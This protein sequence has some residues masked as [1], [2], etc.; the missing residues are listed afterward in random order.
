MVEK[1]DPPE[2]VKRYHVK[3]YSRVSTRTWGNADVDL[4]EIFV[5]KLLEEI[6]I[7]PIV[8]FIPNIHNTK[9]GLCIATEEGN[10]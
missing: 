7:G 3:I 6:N 1:T 8:H 4:R 9:F 5:Y 10:F 2:S